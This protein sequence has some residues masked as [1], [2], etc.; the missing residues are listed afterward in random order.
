MKDVVVLVGS[1]FGRT[2]QE[3]GTRG[4]DH[5]K[6]GAW[7][8][9]GGAVPTGQRVLAAS[10]YAIKDAI[11]ARTPSDSNYY[12][13]FKVNYKDLI[14]EIMVKHLGLQQGQLGSIFPNYSF[15]DQKLLA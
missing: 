13:P 7:F 12:I 9:F 14:G 8:A 1:E 11:A 15:K 6:G 2:M 3:N 4:A 5:G 10:D